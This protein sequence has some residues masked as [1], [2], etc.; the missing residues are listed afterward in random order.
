MPL[1]LAP[2]NTGYDGAELVDKY[3]NQKHFMEEMGVRG[4]MR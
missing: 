4:D 1:F 2:R 3:L